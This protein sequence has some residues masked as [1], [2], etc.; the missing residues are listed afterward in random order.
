[1]FLEKNLLRQTIE[2]NKYQQ[3]T[4][5]IGTPAYEEISPEKSPSHCIANDGTVA[6]EKLKLEVIENVPSTSEQA[7][8]NKNMNAVSFHAIYNDM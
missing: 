1:M 5:I 6:V 8:A 3:K 4:D 7:K 2:E